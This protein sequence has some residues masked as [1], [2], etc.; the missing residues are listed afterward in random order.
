MNTKTDSRLKYQLDHPGFLVTFEGQEEV[1]DMLV[2]E[3]IQNTIFS[4]IED[5]SFP[6]DKEK[7]NAGMGS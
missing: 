3:E 5:K 7:K 2:H 1:Y 6:T 4:L